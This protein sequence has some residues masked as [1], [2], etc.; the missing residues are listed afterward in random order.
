MTP[1][2]SFGLT[3][4]ARMRYQALAVENYG[5]TPECLENEHI[6]SVKIR[7]NH[8]QGSNIKLKGDNR[9]HQTKK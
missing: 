1:A 9:K 5:S 4:M 3:P 2:A 7:V 8:M 6:S